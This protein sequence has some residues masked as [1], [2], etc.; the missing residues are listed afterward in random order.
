MFAAYVALASDDV[1]KLP[2]VWRKAGL[3]NAAARNCEKQH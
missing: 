3:E 2:R 1:C